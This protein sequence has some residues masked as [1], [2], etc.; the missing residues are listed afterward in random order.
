MLIENSKQTYYSK[1]SSKLANPATSS[2]TSC[3]I[4]KTFLNNEKI[5]CIPLVFH[6]NKFTPN[7][8]EKAELFNTFFA[9]QCTLLNNS[10]VLPDNLAKPTNKS[11][12]TV[13]FTTDD[14]S[15]II[16]NLEPNKSHS[17][18]MLSIRMIK[19]C[20]NSMVLTKVRNELKRPKTI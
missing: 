6:E 3:F 16:I 12:D 11:L 17:P 13:N 7:F 8:K 1:L 20:G 9:H 5:S 19:L 18:E 15:E 2:K 4:L 14:I 10:S